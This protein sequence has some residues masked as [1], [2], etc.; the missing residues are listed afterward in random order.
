M[1]SNIKRASSIDVARFA[2]VSQATVSRVFSGS[3]NVSKK[4]R[5]R[6]MDAAKQLNYKPNLLASALN[7]KHAHI[8]ALVN[9]AFNTALYT[10]KC[11]NAFTKYIQ[12]NDC[13]VMLLSINDDNK[14]ENVIE[15]AFGYQI[16]GIIVLSITLDSNLAEQCNRLGV[17]V[18]LFNREP[19]DK[20]V[21]SV[22][23]NNRKAGFDIAMNF[24]DKGHKRLAYISGDI[25]SSTNKERY[26]GYIDAIRQEGLSVFDYYEGDFTYKSG[27]EAAKA[28]LSKKQ[29]PD[30][31]FSANDD[32]AYGFID[33]AEIN[34]N[35]KIPNDISII[36]FD[37]T[38]MSSFPRYNLTTVEQPVEYMAKIAVDL[39]YS[40][41]HG[42]DNYK[43]SVNSISISGNFINRSSVLE[44]NK[45]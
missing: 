2:N 19:K 14:L 5:K 36:G 39:L 44:R 7:Q 22:C 32:M 28:L 25:N 10:K 4:T 43:N 45:N 40:I 29:I 33:S 15:K 24:I 9:P 1:P 12:L 31:I 17:P 41:I 16:D 18:L 27:Y 13:V 26:D 34:F 21:L 42:N 30:A 8:I 35:I 3:N 23:L 38:E 37:N 11:I 20:N 6:V